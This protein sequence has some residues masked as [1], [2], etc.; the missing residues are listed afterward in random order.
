MQ[1][2]VD[3]HITNG[4]RP[5]ELVRHA[6]EI[7]IGAA[8]AY[9]GHKSGCVVRGIDAI[10]IVVAD[11]VVVRVQ[12][13]HTVDDAVI[14]ENVTECIGRRISGAGIDLVAILVVADLIR[15]RNVVAVGRPGIASVLARGGV[16]GMKVGCRSRALRSTG[17]EE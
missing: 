11:Q 1:R 17:L 5:C 7:S 15:E 12:I 8:A 10:H 13:V 6:I 16:G 4:S 2:A 9:V 3:P 14:A